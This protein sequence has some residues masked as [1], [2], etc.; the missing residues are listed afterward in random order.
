MSESS[1]VQDSQRIVDERRIPPQLIE[2]EDNHVQHEDQFHD[3][4]LDPFNYEEVSKTTSKYAIYRITDMKTLN[5]IYTLAQKKIKPE[6]GTQPGTTTV[7]Q[8]AKQIRDSQFEKI[9]Q[10]LK[11]HGVCHVYAGSVG[12]FPP[13]WVNWI[14][15]ASEESDCDIFSEYNRRRHSI[16][17]DLTPSG[18]QHS[19]VS[20]PPL[21]AIIQPASLSDTNEQIPATENR[22]I[23]HL[24]QL[25]IKSIDTDDLEVL[26]GSE[27]LD[28]E[29][30]EDSPN[31]G[32]NLHYLQDQTWF[33]SSTAL[34]LHRHSSDADLSLLHTKLNILVTFSDLFLNL[35][36]TI[37]M[38]FQRLSEASLLITGLTKPQDTKYLRA[39]KVLLLYVRSS[40]P[41]FEAKDPTPDFPVLHLELFF[42]TLISN[43]RII[44]DPKIPLR[45]YIEGTQLNIDRY[46]ALIS[47]VFA[48]KT[49]LFK[50]QGI[51]T[52]SSPS[53]TRGRNHDRAHAW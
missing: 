27:D 48:L 7:L 37:C 40:Q 23:E 4:E 33:Q 12:C 50:A 19:T 51:V 9:Q 45:H 18:L 43:D 44:R 47:G 46:S 25:C 6:R 29:L 11:A 38:E 52:K 36:N 3:E 24:D 1:N 28:G 8:F 32:D 20:S 42:S 22:L 10:D 53:P 17:R 49:E 13:R 35:V 2:V 34:R 30:F 16:S 14:H 5:G 39:Y 26:K 31:Y 41:P 21:S 15:L